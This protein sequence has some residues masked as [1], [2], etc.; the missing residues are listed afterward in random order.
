MMGTDRDAAHDAAVEKKVPAVRDLISAFQGGRAPQAIASARPIN[1][2]SILLS[3]SPVAQDSE[4]N[5][6]RVSEMIS[7]FN[8]RQS[9][10]PVPSRKTSASSISGP[11]GKKPDTPLI[12]KGSV[13]P[14]AQLEE[15]CNPT[16]TSG[17]SPDDQH[18]QDG[19]KPV[20]EK[21]TENTQVGVEVPQPDCSDCKS[22]ISEASTVAPTHRSSI[23]E[24]IREEVN[25]RLE[26]LKAQF[27]HRQTLAMQQ[28]EALQ[29]RSLELE[30]E[31]DLR[32][33]R[34]S[35]RHVPRPRSETS[36]AR[37]ASANQP[38]HLKMTPHDRRSSSSGGTTTRNRQ[39][40][41]SL[42]SS[43]PMSTASGSRRRQS[44]VVEIEWQRRMM[45]EQR[46]HLLNDLFPDGGPR[47]PVPR[48]PRPLPK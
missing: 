6:R 23:Q 34:E 41:H 10:T 15:L 22:Q 46:E 40:P 3:P 8:R 9:S 16:S 5:Q 12:E 28:M 44:Q 25:S 11:E 7:V 13:N 39:K 35:A 29:Q 27:T 26:S 18:V 19:E 42:M 47:R 17:P 14:K 33:H 1:D 45:M 31:V 2:S 4:Q 36:S 48:L 32:T 21:I 38:A 30:R 24:Q 37:K 43:T 20:G